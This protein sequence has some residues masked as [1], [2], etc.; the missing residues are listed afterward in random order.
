MTASKRESSGLDLLI[1][2]D[3]TVVSIDLETI[4]EDLGHSVVAVAGHVPAALEAIERLDAELDGVLLDAELAGHSASVV[5]ER[6]REKSI[7]F[8]IISGHA[9]EELRQ[10]GFEEAQVRKPVDGAVIGAALGE[11]PFWRA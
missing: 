7:P 1:V 4:L 8:V 11:V 3:E 2:E 6:L 9:H 10:L 5:A